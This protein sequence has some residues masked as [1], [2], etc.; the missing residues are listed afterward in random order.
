MNDACAKVDTAMPTIIRNVKNN[1][2]IYSFLPSSFC[3]SGYVCLFSVKAVTGI[4]F[5]VEI[6]RKKGG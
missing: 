2:F 5:I 3:H 1:F 6:R 4:N